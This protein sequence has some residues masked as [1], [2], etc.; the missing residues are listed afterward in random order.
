[1]SDQIYWNLLISLKITQHD[2]V[3]K[4][5]IQEKIES[6]LINSYRLGP[7]E[8][9]M[10]RSFI[11][12]LWNLICRNMVS[13][14]NFQENISTLHKKYLRSVLS[15]R[16]TKALKISYIKSKTMTHQTF[17][18]HKTPFVLSEVT[19]ANSLNLISRCPL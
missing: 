2:V 4:L 17:Y 13:F 5:K 11:Y 12:Y 15:V 1:M 3:W 9:S 7:R 14:F 18:T 10:N 19:F 6:P 16:R 8:G